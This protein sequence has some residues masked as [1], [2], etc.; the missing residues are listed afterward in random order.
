M[1]SYLP[2]CCL[3]AC[4]H[5]DNVR[6]AS[7]MGEAT[8]LFTR[9][10]LC[11]VCWQRADTCYMHHSH[12]IDILFGLDAQELMPQLPI[13]F[14]LSS[15]HVSYFDQPGTTHSCCCPLMYFILF[16]LNHISFFQTVHLVKVGNW[17]KDDQH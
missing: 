9:S 2:S 7:S 15:R 11:G 13:F 14:S 3:Q 1:G 6:F 4:D 17:S 10:I 12:K 16:V 8:N 5:D